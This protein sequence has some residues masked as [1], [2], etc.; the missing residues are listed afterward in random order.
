MILTIQLILTGAAMFFAG[1]K[2]GFSDGFKAAKN[3]ITKQL[4]DRA[5]KLGL[6]KDGK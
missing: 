5:K 1:Y 3:L 6:K 2:V 4:I